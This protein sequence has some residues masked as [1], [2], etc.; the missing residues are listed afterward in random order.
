MQFLDNSQKEI[1]STLVT[2]LSISRAFIAIDHS[3]ATSL[4]TESLN[5]STSYSFHSSSH[6]MPFPFSFFTAC[7]S[8]PFKLRIFFSSL[9]DPF[10]FPL[11]LTSTFPDNALFISIDVFFSFFTIWSQLIPLFPP[12]QPSPCFFTVLGPIIP[13][14]R[15][16][17]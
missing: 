12:R 17:N 13:T 11:Y 14:R 5:T 9:N 3:S 4:F 6:I 7:H 15:N 8:P 10:S 2:L 1:D 16:I